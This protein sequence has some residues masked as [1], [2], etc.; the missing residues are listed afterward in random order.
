MS[1]IANPK[2][3]VR[4]EILKRLPEPVK[5]SKA[6]ASLS[7]PE[8]QR[9]LARA[10]LDAIFDHSGPIPL[11]FVVAQSSLS[12]SVTNHVGTVL[13]AGQGGRGGMG[14]WKTAKGY[15]PCRENAV[16]VLPHLTEDMLTSFLA[17]RSWDADQLLE[18]VQNLPAGG[19]KS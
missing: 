10:L 11:S 4:E 19:G 1:D 2:I 17:D 3:A 8:K 5:S 18:R 14:L 7:Q 9:C 6:T 13:G 12:D 15:L 16:L